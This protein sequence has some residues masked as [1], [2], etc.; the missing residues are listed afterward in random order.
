M[1]R[2]LQPGPVA[3]RPCQEFCAVWRRGRLR[4]QTARH[5]CILLQDVRFQRQAPVTFGAPHLDITTNPLSSA[6]WRRGSGRGGAPQEPLAG[7]DQKAPLP[8]P[9]PALRCGERESTTVVVAR[10]ARYLSLAAAIFHSWSWT[11]EPGLR[12]L[13]HVKI[14]S[15]PHCS[16]KRRSLSSRHQSGHNI[17]SWRK[18]IRVQDERASPLFRAARSPKIAI[19]LLLV[20]VTRA[21]GTP[22]N[23]NFSD[24]LAISGLTNTVTGSNVDATTEQGEPNHA[25]NSG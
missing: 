19:L 13:A 4:L 20:T 9:L 5:L 2:S 24:R 22:T 7:T 17:V 25:G 10:C 8:S 12:F 1:A 21:M 15:L 18:A 3:V 14:R 6:E 11:F 23:D 16:R